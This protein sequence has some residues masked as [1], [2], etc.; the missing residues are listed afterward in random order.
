[1][2][3]ESKE[4]IRPVL[5][6]RYFRLLLVWLGCMIVASQAPD[7][8][9]N[10]IFLESNYVSS[11]IIGRLIDGTI[12]KPAAYVDVILVKK[13]EL[14]SDLNVFGTDL[15]QAYKTRTNDQGSF[16]FYDIPPGVYIIV[17]QHPLG[18]FAARNDR[19]D[20]LIV[21]VGTSKI[22]DVGTLYLY[23]P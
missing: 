17:I 23:I 5:A 3:I 13:L 7:T 20:L 4:L 14:S 21:E 6:F 18:L 11:I 15:R 12:N 9:F 10:Y 1:M 19:R 2:R 8:N 16:L 22:V